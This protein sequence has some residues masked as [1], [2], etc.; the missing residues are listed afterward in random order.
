[1]SVN[2]FHVTIPIKVKLYRLNQ[3]I[4]GVPKQKHIVFS[5]KDG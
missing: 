1:V 3:V 4:Y 5:K 2:T